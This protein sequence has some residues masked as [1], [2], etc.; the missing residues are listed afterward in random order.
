MDIDEIL[1]QSED[2]EIMGY[3]ADK[4]GE[5]YSGRIRGILE[6]ENNVSLLEDENNESLESL[7][8]IVHFVKSEASAAPAVNR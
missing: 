3:F 5:A 8:D 6:A 1:I 4:A 2:N 7:P